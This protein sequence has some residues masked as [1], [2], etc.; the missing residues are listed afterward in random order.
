[1][2][3]LLIVFVRF[4]R[5]HCHLL[6]LPVQR[7]V[8]KF[9]QR[10]SIVHPLILPKDPVFDSTQGGKSH[11][12]A[13]SVAAPQ[14]SMWKCTLSLRCEPFNLSLIRRG[15]GAGGGVES[16]YS[17]YKH[18]TFEEKGERKPSG[19]EVRLLTILAPC[20]WARTGS[21]GTQMSRRVSLKRSPEY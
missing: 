2:T 17:V 21:A 13:G 20:H 5:V 18:I 4:W 3:D 10:V 12:V 15:G 6:E 14:P 8:H 9:Y 11:K 7:D 16:K 19:T 1:M